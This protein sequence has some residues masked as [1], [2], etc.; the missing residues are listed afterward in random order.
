MYRGVIESRGGGFPGQ[1]AE[2]WDDSA[3]MKVSGSTMHRFPSGLLKTADTALL[4]LL[5]AANMA[6]FHPGAL[7]AH[8]E[9]AAS[10]AV[11]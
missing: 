1:E 6:G 4:S 9:Q 8:G 5:A 3:I 7:V 11:E 2:G 10:I